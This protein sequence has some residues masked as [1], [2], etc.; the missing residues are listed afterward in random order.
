MMRQTR[1]SENPDRRK[2]PHIGPQGNSHSKLPIGSYKAATHP[3][4]VN[5]CALGSLTAVKL[6]G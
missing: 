1:N 3:T 5:F 6:F 4:E 2:A